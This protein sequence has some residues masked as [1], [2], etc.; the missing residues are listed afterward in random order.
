MRLATHLHLV[1]RLRMC[2]DVCSHCE[3]AL[4]ACRGATVLLLF[5]EFKKECIWEGAYT[6]ICCPC[7]NVCK[8]RIMDLLFFVV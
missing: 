2:G 3:Y 6:G 7:L 8:S 1:P 5:C 4:K